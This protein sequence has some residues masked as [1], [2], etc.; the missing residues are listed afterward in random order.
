MLM[1]LLQI[2]NTFLLQFHRTLRGK[3]SIVCKGIRSSS[4][5]I[6][7]RAENN[8]IF[9]FEALFYQGA[10]YFTTDINQQIHE[11]LYVAV[12]QGY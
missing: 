4:F 11:Q 12:A 6:R 8:S 7:E 10:L 1:W 2:L 9:L 5:K 3:C